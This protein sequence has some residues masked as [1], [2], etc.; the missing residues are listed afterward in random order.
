MSVLQARELIF[1]K[2]SRYNNI[3]V[4]RHGSLIE[5]S[6]GHN[7]QI[8]TE[9][10]YNTV[11]DLDLPVEYTRY[12]T[13][14][15]TYAVNNN[16]ILEIGFGGGRTVWYLH[17]LLPESN[18]TS[19]ELD[20]EVYEAALSYFGINKDEDGFDVIIEDG[21]RYLI[22]N[23]QLW[24][25]IM[26]DAYRGP[27]VPFHLLTKEFYQMTKDRLS[28]GGVLVQNI[29]PT[30][31][32]YEAAIATIGSVFDNVEVFDAQGNVVLIAYS[33]EK[34]SKSTLRT[35]AEFLD[36]T[37]KF[38]YSQKS[39]LK[40]RKYLR[41]LPNSKIL[42][43]DFAPVETLRATERHNRKLDEFQ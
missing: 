10:V 18:I 40:R 39:M 17:K 1:S 32:L 37:H 31:M 19:I 24:D 43:D 20:R 27:F 28:D 34:K 30:T 11:N 36:R 3:F 22:K 25:L 26:V 5:M 8:F 16:D 21:R 42:S 35:K 33:G 38:P 41:F 2:E 4:F 12:M 9:S 29:E 7:R 14:G 23:K 6:F 13:L 15:L